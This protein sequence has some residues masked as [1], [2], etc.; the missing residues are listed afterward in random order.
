MEH[1]NNKLETTV[2]YQVDKQKDPSRDTTVLA[3]AIQ[4]FP[5]HV[6]VPEI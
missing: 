5:D 4:V 2:R 3:P 1:G 6:P